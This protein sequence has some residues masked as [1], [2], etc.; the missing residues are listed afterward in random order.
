MPQYQP[1]A[2]SLLRYPP[3]AGVRWVVYHPDVQKDLE[4]F[5]K[6]PLNYFHQLLL[7]NDAQKST[8]VLILTGVPPR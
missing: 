4:I 2:L 6:D 1:L 5:P 3:G 7:V 8:T